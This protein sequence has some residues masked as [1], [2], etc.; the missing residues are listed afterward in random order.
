VHGANGVMETRM[1]SAGVYKA[2]YAQLLYA[3]QAL[4][5]WVFNKLVNGSIGYGDEAIYRVVYYFSLYHK[6]LTGYLTLF[7][8]GYPILPN[9]KRYICKDRVKINYTTQ[10]W[11]K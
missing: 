7:H 6:A 11:E 8:N 5:V 2:A 10:K 3:A 9:N 1:Y 4:K